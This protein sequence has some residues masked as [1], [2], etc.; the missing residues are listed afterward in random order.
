MEIQKCHILYSYIFIDVQYVVRLLRSISKFETRFPVAYFQLLPYWW[1]LFPTRFF[2]LNQQFEICTCF[3]ISVLS[4]NP[5][6]VGIWYVHKNFFVFL[7]PMPS[8]SCATGVFW[9][10]EWHS[11]TSL[12]KK[13]FQVKKMTFIELFPLLSMGHW[14]TIFIKPFFDFWNICPMIFATVINLVHLLILRSWWGSTS[15]WNW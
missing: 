1:V 9:A 3:I 8:V 14:K 2:R 13:K 5:S 6:G 11:C 7:L 10:G 12:S 15:R 4:G